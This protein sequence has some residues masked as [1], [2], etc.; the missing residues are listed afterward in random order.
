MVYWVTAA[1]A[2]FYFLMAPVRLGAIYASNRE[3][4]LRLGV[5][6]GPVRLQPDAKRLRL[7]APPE[8]GRIPVK[9]LVKALAFLLRGITVE[10]LAVDLSVHLDDAA[11]SALL[12]GLTRALATSIQYAFPRLPVRAR[13]T[14]DFS[15]ARTGLRAGGILSIRLG[16]IIGAGGLF[17]LYSIA[18]R[19]HA[20]INTR[21][22]A[23]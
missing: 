3:N 12:C 17:L 11:H 13:I 22:R 23:S 6:I 14:A 9:A 7:G 8:A 15:S 19:L 1:A 2:L 16:H 5:L 4:P 18:G 20:W 21:L 10:R